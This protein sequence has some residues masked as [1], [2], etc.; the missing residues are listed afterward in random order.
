MTNRTRTC[1]PSV[2]NTIPARW[3]LPIWPASTPPGVDRELWRKIQ[4]RAAGYKPAGVPADQVRAWSAFCLAVFAASQPRNTPRVGDRLGALH[5]FLF[6]SEARLEESVGEIFAPERISRF[7]M[8]SHVTRK[9]PSSRQHVARALNAATAALLGSP[10]A[11]PGTKSHPAARALARIQ[12]LSATPGSAQKS[13]RRVLA[14]LRSEDPTEPIP[15]R[16]ATR[17]SRTL[18]RSGERVTQ[19]VMQVVR[20]AILACRPVSG[21]VLLKGNSQLSGFPAAMASQSASFDP[22][23]AR[24][25]IA[26]ARELPTSQEAP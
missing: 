22:R 5:H 17:V 8:S 6:A 19:S 21:M 13:A 24:L 14:W 9:S 25:H 7:L 15:R 10:K 23:D 26:A 16:D 18:G 2:P 4:R 3:I 20:L 1:E 11:C 12:D